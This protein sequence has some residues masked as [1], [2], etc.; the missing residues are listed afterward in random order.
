MT[1]TIEQLSI[2]NAQL[3]NENI[4]EIVE[5]LVLAY[6]NDLNRTSDL[7]ALIPQLAAKQLQIKDKRIVEF[8]V[9]CDCLLGERLTYP[10]T[11]RKGWQK[12]DFATLL[13]GCVA[14]FPDGNCNGAS[15]SQ[16]AFFQE[17]IDAIQ[18]RIG[19][20]YESVDDW[21]WIC[22]IAECR[23]WMISVIKQN[24]DNDFKEPAM[25]KE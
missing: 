24:I 11:L 4:K 2:I 6:A 22:N 20:D 19:F 10:M 16:Q 25:R 15:A 9:A 3:K 12:I 13:Y 14:R 1:L 21:Y 23:E 17:F 5:T 7:L 8:S 18:N